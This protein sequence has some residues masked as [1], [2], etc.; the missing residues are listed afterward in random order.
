MIL[1]SHQA[2]D[3]PPWWRIT[4]SDAAAVLA[5]G[6]CMCANG[7]APL[8]H[9]LQTASALVLHPGETAQR[10]SLAAH[11]SMHSVLAPR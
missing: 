5:E 8:R 3:A 10:K 6:V 7:I 2:T 9:E 1:Q 4:A 11:T